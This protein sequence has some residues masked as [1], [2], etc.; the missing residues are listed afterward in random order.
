MKVQLAAMNITAIMNIIMSAA[1]YFYNK[2]FLTN[3]E[4]WTLY[5]RSW[6]EIPMCGITVVKSNL[7]K[8]DIIFL[9]TVGCLNLNQCC[10]SYCA[11]SLNSIQGCLILYICFLPFCCKTSLWERERAS[12]HLSFLLF[13]STVTWW[14]IHLV[15]QTTQY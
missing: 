5:P 14:I 11:L 7:L 6:L 4:D 1:K 13:L 3:A 15:L 12:F 9:T 2:M 10:G 8:R